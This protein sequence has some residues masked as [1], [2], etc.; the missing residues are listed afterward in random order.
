MEAKCFES[1]LK[2]VDSRRRKI[3]RVSCLLLVD[4]HVWVGCLGRTIHILDVETLCCEFNEHYNIYVTGFATTCLIEK[5]S[6]EQMLTFEFSVVYH[7]V[8]QANGTG[9]LRSF[10]I[11]SS[12]LSKI[13]VI[14]VC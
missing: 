14:I 11:A 6:F 7:F 10:H 8:Q 9:H 12:I 5:G 4:F 1:D 13:H 3:V 2:I